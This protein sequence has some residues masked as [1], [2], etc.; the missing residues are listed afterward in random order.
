MLLVLSSQRRLRKDKRQPHF[1]ITIAKHLRFFVSRNF[2]FGL[3]LVAFFGS[4]TEGPVSLI[5]AVLGS[6]PIIT[7]LMMG[8]IGSLFQ[9]TDMK[10][11]MEKKSFFPL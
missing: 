8:L 4:L 10:A 11:R 6:R 9:I 3:G 1:D 7:L 5:A 2:V